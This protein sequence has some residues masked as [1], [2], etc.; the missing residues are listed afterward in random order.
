MQSINAYITLVSNAVERETNFQGQLDALRLENAQLLRQ[1]NISKKRMKRQLER[2]S[3]SSATI[4][5]K[6]NKK[7]LSHT[8]TTSNPLPTVSKETNLN[9]SASIMKSKK[10]PSKMKPQLRQSSMPISNTSSQV[11]NKLSSPPSLSSIKNKVDALN[12]SVNSS[13][14]STASRKKRS[15]EDIAEEVEKT[16]TL[17]EYPTTNNVQAASTSPPTAVEDNVLQSP[18]NLQSEV[19]TKRRRRTTE[20]SINNSNMAVQNNLVYQSIIPN[21][22]FLNYNNTA[23]NDTFDGLIS[24][25]TSSRQNSITATMNSLPVTFNSN[26]N[27]PNNA[28]V[29]DS[30]EPP[31]AVV[32]CQFDIATTSTS[33]FGNEHTFF[34]TF[35]NLEHV[36]SSIPALRTPIGRSNNA[37]SITS[38]A[39][40]NNNHLPSYDPTTLDILNSLMQDPHSVTNGKF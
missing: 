28:E 6:K 36:V 8:A 20:T 15:R 10:L 30:N 14:Q 27:S 9:K 11:T 29:V 2:D 32:P 12:N 26:V 40:P 37:I 23:N 31:A 5:V 13:N 35:E 17:T 4:A 7:L 25:R 3:E 19:I 16:P 33:P 22:N 39:T 38:E 18:L 1:A 21:P 24:S 34:N